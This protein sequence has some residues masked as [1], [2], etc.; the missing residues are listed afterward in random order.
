KGDRDA[1]TLDDIAG[2]ARR[3]PIA[4][5]ALAVCIFSL[6]GFPPTA[7]F[8]GKLY[9]FSSAFSL[10]DN[11]AFHGPLIALAIIGVVNAAIAAAY[12]LRIVGAAYMSEETE[13]PTPAGGFPVR[14]GLGLCALPVLLLFVRPALVLDDARSASAAVRSAIIQ[15]QTQSRSAAVGSPVVNEGL[16]DPVS[17]RYPIPGGDLFENAPPAP[18]GANGL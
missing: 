8:L 13:E 16:E 6:M 11:H 2:V 15:G 1:E 18:L 5:F 7:G 9:I 14:L 17:S 3:A 12:Y 4:T 10:P